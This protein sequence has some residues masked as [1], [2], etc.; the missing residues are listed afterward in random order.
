MKAHAIPQYSVFNG[1]ALWGSYLTLDA[2]KEAVARLKRKG[3]VATIKE[4]LRVW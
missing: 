3:I 1:E 4:R 2:A